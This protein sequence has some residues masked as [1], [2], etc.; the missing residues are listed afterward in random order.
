MI[1]ISSFNL[2]NNN[3]VTTKLEATYNILRENIVSGNLKPGTKLVIRKIAR[4]LGVSEIPVREAIRMLETHGFVK[5]A[6]HS[7]AEV[8]KLEKNDMV[9]IFEIRSILEGY[10]T[11]ISVPHIKGKTIKDLEKLI[12]EMKQCIEEKNYVEFGVLNRK[13]HLL[14]YEFSPNKKLLELILNM[15]EA[16]ERARAIFALCNERAIMALKEH[17]NILEAIKAK[18]ADKVEVLVKNHRRESGEYLSKRNKID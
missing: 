14:I 6:P 10:A 17:E 8:S 11:K 7:V 4:E 18:D 2:N 15:Y 1:Y 9:E 16:S 3:V 12:E 13:F 5:M